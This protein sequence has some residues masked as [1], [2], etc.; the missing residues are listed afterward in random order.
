MIIG[1]AQPGIVLTLYA[2]RLTLLDSCFTLCLE[3]IQREKASVL[4]ERT[5]TH[6]GDGGFE[7]VAVLVM[8]SWGAVG[9][10]GGISFI[11]DYCFSHYRRSMNLP[12][13]IIAYCIPLRH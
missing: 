4:R 11:V 5:I 6:S 7:C 13:P 8:I 9:I 10:L 3:K 2:E 12:F 1:D